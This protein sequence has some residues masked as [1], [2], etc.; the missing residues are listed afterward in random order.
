MPP[1]LDSLRIQGSGSKLSQRLPVASAACWPRVSPVLD[2]C[3]EK[4][5]IPA[6]QRDGPGGQACTQ[7]TERAPGG[8]SEWAPSPPDSPP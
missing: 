6:L 4:A 7:L 3:K 1:H 2:T 8:L 5:E